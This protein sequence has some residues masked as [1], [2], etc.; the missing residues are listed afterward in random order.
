MYHLIMR[1][2]SYVYTA[3]TNG[4][5]EFLLSSKRCSKCICFPSRLSISLHRAPIQ[6]RLSLLPYL[7]PVGDTACE[8]TGVTP[9]PPD[10]CGE[11]G[12]AESSGA[13]RKVTFGSRRVGIRRP[14]AVLDVPAVC[15]VPCRCYAVPC[16]AGA[17]PCPC[18][19]FLSYAVFRTGH[20]GR[21]GQLRT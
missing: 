11:G 21:G 10:R 3:Y 13:L 16:R 5:I 2:V 17:V 15:A 19:V 4:S 18:R 14:T 8:V 7:A 12:H 1:Q 20:R 6:P 9:P